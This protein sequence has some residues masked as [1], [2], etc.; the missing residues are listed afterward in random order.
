MNEPSLIRI[1]NNRMESVDYLVEHF[2]R[3]ILT[4]PDDHPFVPKLWEDEFLAAHLTVRDTE[5]VAWRVEKVRTSK[6][7]RS[8]EAVCIPW[9]DW[10]RQVLV[11]DQRF[12]ELQGL[13]AVWGDRQPEWKIS[14][15]SWTVG[16]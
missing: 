11:T 2:Q 9:Q 14:F 7:T 10:I 13:K 8:V 1:W 12:L 6:A 16:D 3:G 5:E 4:L 15:G